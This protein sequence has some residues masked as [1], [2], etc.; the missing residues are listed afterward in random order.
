VGRCKPCHD[1]HM[2]SLRCIIND[3]GA[4]INAGLSPRTLVLDP[5]I[6]R[7]R[8]FN[9]KAD[10][11]CNLAMDLGSGFTW[12]APLGAELLRDCIAFQ[13]FSDGSVRTASCS[14]VGYVIYVWSTFGTF[15]TALQS[16]AHCL[17]KASLR[18]LHD[19]FWNRGSRAQNCY[20][21]YDRT[22]LQ[23]M[24]TTTSKVG[25]LR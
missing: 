15:A 25:Y 19:T 24:N 22:D 6:W 12:A 9:K 21:R 23:P 13:V 4:L 10:T 7:A 1:H 17:S 18:R 8:S 2:T 11:A 14:A 5:V 3:L 16:E 20:P